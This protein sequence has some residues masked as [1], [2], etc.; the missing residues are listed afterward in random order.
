MIVVLTY[1]DGVD[2]D[3]DDDDALKT[4]PSPGLEQILMHVPARQLQL[5]LLNEITLHNQRVPIHSGG[6]RRQGKPTSTLHNS[7]HKA[8]A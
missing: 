1:P 8:T 6:K 3:D 4:Q 7:I 2:D 5:P